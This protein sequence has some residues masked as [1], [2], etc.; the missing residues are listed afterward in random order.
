[1]VYL[2]VYLFLNFYILFYVIYFNHNKYIIYLR[3][4]GLIISAHLN[5][6][7][8]LIIN[9]RVKKINLKNAAKRESAGPWS[10]I[11]II[12]LTHKSHL[13]LFST[14]LS[15]S[16]S[17]ETLKTHKSH[18]QVRSQLWILSD[19]KRSLNHTVMSVLL[20]LCLIISMITYSS[21]PL[22]LSVYYS[23]LLLSLFLVW[24]FPI[25]FPIFS[26]CQ[27]CEKCFLAHKKISEI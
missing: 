3:F 7:T 1:M 9:N 20:T 12:H 5:K 23:S 16:R 17:L 6:P 22:F 25:L 10:P 27:C 21:K 15:L 11:I 2:Y 4:N 14:T 18:Q 13:P 8:H 24:F 19:K 26:L